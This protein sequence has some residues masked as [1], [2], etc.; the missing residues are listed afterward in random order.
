MISKNFEHNT[1]K[2]ALRLCNIC[3][4]KTNYLIFGISFFL[5]FAI[6][7]LS[8]KLQDF[9]IQTYFIDRGRNSPDSYR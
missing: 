8:Y 9:K 3:F 5:Q 6:P 1:N 7:L 4:C 2:K